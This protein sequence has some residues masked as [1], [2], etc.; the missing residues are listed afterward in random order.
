MCL[1]TH[2]S[3]PNMTKAMKTILKW[4]KW[5]LINDELENISKLSCIHHWFKGWD[6][7]WTFGGTSDFHMPNCRDGIEAE[8]STVRAGLSFTMRWCHQPLILESD[9][10]EM[11]KLIW[12]EDMCRLVYRTLVEDIKSL[13]KDRRIYFTD[14]NRILNISSYFMANYA[15][16]NRHTEVWHLPCLV[17]LAEIRQ[18]F[19]FA[20]ILIFFE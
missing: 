16:L 1:D 14:I 3:R 13:P 20:D 7:C 6:E 5:L 17:G 15:R 12:N 18:D 19:V 4:I 8:L 11:E 9:C 2:V 10:L